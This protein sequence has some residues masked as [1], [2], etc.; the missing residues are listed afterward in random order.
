MDDLEGMLD[1]AHGHE[2]LAIVAAV[3]HHGVSEAFHN[4]AL[5][6]SEALGG[7]AARAVGQVLGVLLLDS[8]VILEQWKKLTQ[9]QDGH[10]R[11]P[12]GPNTTLT[13][14]P[15]H[16]WGFGCEPLPATKNKI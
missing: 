15:T 1:N 7:I 8:N 5:C 3:H 6:L 2:L 10:P 4:G 13:G 11:V 9:E 14:A 16:L 12:G